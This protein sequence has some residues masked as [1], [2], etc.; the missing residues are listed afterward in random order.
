M[1]A[2]VSEIMIAVAS[3]KSVTMRQQT[4]QKLNT[5]QTAK[6]LTCGGEIESCIKSVPSESRAGDLIINLI[7]MCSRCHSPFVI[8]Q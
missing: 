5:R 3:K 8:P 7:I 2:A 1:S 6:E 4:L